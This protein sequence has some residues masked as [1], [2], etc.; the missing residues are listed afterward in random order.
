MPLQ[1]FQP[2]PDCIQNTTDLRRLKRGGLQQSLSKKASKKRTLFMNSSFS[3]QE[4]VQRVTPLRSSRNSRLIKMNIGI[5]V[6]SSISSV[7]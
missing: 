3:F 5:P 6:T 2:L 4:A 1:S 7:P